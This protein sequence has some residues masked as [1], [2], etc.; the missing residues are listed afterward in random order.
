MRTLIT[1]AGKEVRDGLR[2]RWVFSAILLLCALSLALSLLGSAPGGAVKASPLGVTVAS[3]A[4]LGVYLIPLIAL[5]LSYNAFVGEMERGT[6]LLLLTYPVARWQVVLGKFLGHWSILAISILGGYGI[7]GLVI[8]A[9][10][11]TDGAE[12]W[13]AY[14]M[15]MASSALLGAIFVALGYL[16]SVLASE[17]RMAAGLAV[18]LWIVMVVIYDLALIGTLVADTT[19]MVSETLFSVLLLANPTDAYRIFNLT[20]IEGVAKA[21]GMVGIGIKLGLGSS[22]ALLIMAAWTVLPLAAT[23]AVFGRREV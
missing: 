19:G 4:S 3:L 23:V 6:M 21:A 17:E 15:M 22:L 8:A 1:L 16:L 12:G 13:Q 14:F 20:A 11:G 9:L 10:G 7:A 5:M 18:G 2:N